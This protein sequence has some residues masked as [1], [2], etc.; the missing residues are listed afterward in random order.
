ML[1]GRQYKESLKDGRKVYLEGRVIEYLGSE[2][3]PGSLNSWHQ[4]CSP[5]VSGGR[6]RCFCSSLPHS[7]KPGEEDYAIACAVPVGSPG[8]HVTNTT[9]HPRSGDP[10]DYPVIL[11]GRV[12]AQGV[13][14]VDGADD[15]PDEGHEHDGGDTRRRREHDRG[16]EQGDRHRPPGQQEGLPGGLVHPF[17]P[18]FSSFVPG[19][20]LGP[21]ALVPAPGV[22]VQLGQDA[23]VHLRRDP[24]A[25]LSRD[26]FVDVRADA[27]HQPFG[28]GLVVPGA[29][30]LQGAHR[31]GDLSLAVYGHHVLR[32]SRQLLRQTVRLPAGRQNAVSLRSVLVFSLPLP[33][34]GSAR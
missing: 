9:Y 32:T 30:V 24:F 6:K 12:L 20:A 13:G 3:A 5:R 22:P 2:P 33:M 34:D 26:P 16:H 28:Q 23:A 10:R 19:H 18:D 17:G 31:G 25:D 14:H 15:D 11:L 29:E 7:M 21:A 8:V 1:T 4:R 27:L